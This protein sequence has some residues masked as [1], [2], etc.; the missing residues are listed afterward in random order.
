V[1]LAALPGGALLSGNAL[2]EFH[3]VSESYLLKHLQALVR[4]GLFESV[5]GPKGGFRLARPPEAVSVL[6]IV[7]AID[8]P[9]PAFRCTEIRQ[10][11]PASLEPS[12]YRLP[13]AIHATMARAEQAWREVLRRQTLADLAGLVAERTDPRAVAMALPWLDQHVRGSPPV[14]PCR[15]RPTPSPASRVIRC[16]PR[17]EVDA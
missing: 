16:T 7:V 17:K 12:A 11:G 14:R 2:A 6:D 13:C 15:P 10:R 5:P 1:L 4:S 8:G 3:G 9:E